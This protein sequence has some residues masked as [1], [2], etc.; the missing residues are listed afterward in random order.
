LKFKKIQQNEKTNEIYK[1]IKI[2][3]NLS[4]EF[5]IMWEGLTKKC[6]KK[7][8]KINNFPSAGADTRGIDPSSSAS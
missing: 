2:N 1:K 7:L 6:G 5:H 3:S 4:K 8:K